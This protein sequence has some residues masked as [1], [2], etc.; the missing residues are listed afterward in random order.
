MKKHSVIPSPL[1]A[2]LLL[3]SGEAPIP[4]FYAG[5]LNSWKGSH[6]QTRQTAGA[7]LSSRNLSKTHARVHTQPHT[8]PLSSAPPRARIQVPPTSLSVLRRPTRNADL[9]QVRMVRS[10]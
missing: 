9:T 8:H 1:S 4:W 2:W 3:H 6:V 5:S 10:N 7:E